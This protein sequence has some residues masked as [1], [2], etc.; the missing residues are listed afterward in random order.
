MYYGFFYP[1]LFERRLGFPFIVF[2]PPFFF[3]T[4]KQGEIF[5]QFFYHRRNRVSFEKI[6]LTKSKNIISYDF[7]PL[8]PLPHCIKELKNGKITDD[9][10]NE[11]ANGKNP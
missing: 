4:T 2:L 11:I 8:L 10:K 7:S 6:Y 3:F 5:S 1:F 9:K